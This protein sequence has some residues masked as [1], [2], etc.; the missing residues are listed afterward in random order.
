MIL[1]QIAQYYDHEQAYLYY[2]SN[3]ETLLDIEKIIIKEHI[4]CDFQ[5]NTAF[6]YTDDKK[7]LS[8]LKKQEQ[9][10][11]QF[12]EKIFQK[13]D[14]LMTIGIENQTVFDPIK[15]LYRIIKICQNHHIDFYENAKATTIKRFHDHYQ[16]TV[17]NHVISCKYLVHATRY[18]FIK[19]GAYFLKLFQ[20]RSYVDIHENI[21]GTNSYISAD[22]SCSY[23]PIHKH[24]CLMI[25]HHS[26]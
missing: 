21:Q 26:S 4:D 11:K 13:N 23:R 7:K 14:H 1:Q 24:H 15:Y 6:I 12:G 25:N 10:L 17:N 9:L 18:P 5:K 20:T 16:V 2:L 22:Y 3:K 19:K 8:S